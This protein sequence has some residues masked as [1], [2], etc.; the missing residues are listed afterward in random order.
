[1][2]EQDKRLEALL[3]KSNRRL[4]ASLKP[5]DVEHIK[6]KVRQKESNGV[7]VDKSW[8]VGVAAALTLL[9]VSHMIVTWMRPSEMEAM[10]QPIATDTISSDEGGMYYVNYYPDHKG[11]DDNILALFM[12]QEQHQQPKVIHS[13]LVQHVDGVM[14]MQQMPI[15]NS[16]YLLLSTYQSLDN[17]SIPAAYQH[18]LFIFDEGQMEPLME[19]EGEVTMM[20]G[21]RFNSEEMGMTIV[22]LF[23]DDTGIHSKVE[24]LSLQV[25]ERICLVLNGKIKNIIADYDSTILEENHRDDPHRLIYEAKEVGRTTLTLQG[26]GNPQSLT[27]QVSD[28]MPRIERIE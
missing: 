20:E 10:N 2:D 8:F 1:M 11:A 9:L 6:K 23:I 25:G 14:S 18:V 4:D 28:D 5:V 19:L 13:Q 22:P 16:R 26:E 21:N 15:E 12:R 24:V 7:R 17:T 27:I 3:H